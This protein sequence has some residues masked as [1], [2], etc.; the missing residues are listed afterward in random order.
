MD[1]FYQPQMENNTTVQA[2]QD[3]INKEPTK[4]KRRAICKF[5]IIA[6]AALVLGLVFYGGFFLGKDGTTGQ[7][8]CLSRAS[9]HNDP[10]P[11]DEASGLAEFTNWS[12][13]QTHR[14]VYQ[15]DS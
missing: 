5:F 12:R 10:L 1:R 15:V 13:Q 8:N 3:T 7:C 2:K 14:R 11:R 9:S 4:K 6:W